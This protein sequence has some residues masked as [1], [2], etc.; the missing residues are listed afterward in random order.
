MT[1]KRNP[2]SGFIQ[3]IV[4]FIVFC[5]IVWYFKIDVRGYVDSHSQIKDILTKTIDALKTLWSDYLV[6][7]GTFI[8]HNII[9]D[10]FWNN[11]TP[12]IPGK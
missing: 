8:W 4:L 12:F 10:I 5:I 11:I 3:I 9:I 1:N 7:A 6:G 2:Q